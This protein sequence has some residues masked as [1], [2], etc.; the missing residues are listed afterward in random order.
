LSQS[1][2]FHQSKRR[3]REKTVMSYP[4]EKKKKKVSSHI[5]TLIKIEKTHVIRKMC[6]VER[7]GGEEQLERT[8]KL[9]GKYPYL[10]KI[11]K[12]AGKY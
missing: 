5:H 8:E 4:G 3:T 12:V 1:R 6:Y 11:K 2:G 10:L 7:R 9:P